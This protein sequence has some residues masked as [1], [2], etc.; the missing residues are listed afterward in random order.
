[1]DK[2][3]VNSGALILAGSETTAT[4]LCGVTYLLTTHPDVLKKLTDEVRSSFVDDAE[5]TL[6]S[7]NKLHYMLACLKE[8]LRRYPPIA[9]VL[10]RQVPKG[11]A[12]VA[13]HFVPEGTIIGIPQFAINHCPELWTDPM[14]FKPERFLGDQKYANDK[15]D[16]M[17][18]FSIGPR[19][20]VGKK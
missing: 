8:G 6:I 5:I 18:P 2:L 9:G 12:M 4:L 10:P 13:G 14:E 11:G 15:I 3:I 20:C 17:Q 7:V 1:M 16:S 19:N